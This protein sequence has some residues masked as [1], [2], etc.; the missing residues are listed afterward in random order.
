MLLKL[1][2]M[3]KKLFYSTVLLILIFISGCKKENVC[4]NMPEGLYEGWFT[5][6][7]ASSV[8]IPLY[9]SKI[10][11]NTLVINS[12]GES[13]YGPFVKR[14]GCSIGGVIEGKSCLGEV[15]LKKGNY[16]I[17]GT[18]SYLANNGGQGNP[19]PQYYEVHGTFEIKSN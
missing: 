4:G 15:Q 3:K 2:D 10:D 13:S 5:D 14:D 6:Y 9:V 17:K 1:W 16:L 7:G 11:E 18:Y 12:T 8:Y 19:N